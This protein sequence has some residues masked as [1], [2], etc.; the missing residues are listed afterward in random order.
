M[1]II[2][3]VQYASGFL[4]D[5]F[6]VYPN[7]Y[8]CIPGSSMVLLLSYISI[9][10]KTIICTTAAVFMFCYDWW[11]CMVINISVPGTV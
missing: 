2:G 10:N 8:S 11:L 7:P 3:I 5:N 1:A 4:P 6:T 9:Y